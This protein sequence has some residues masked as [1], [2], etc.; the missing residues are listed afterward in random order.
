MT[1]F[2]TM[3]G[4]RHQEPATTPYACHGVF[5]DRFIFSLNLSRIQI[6]TGAPVTNCNH[7]HGLNVDMSARCRHVHVRLHV[8]G[9]WPISR[10]KLL[11]ID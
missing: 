8:H 3:A 9:N 2:S 5:T 4:A 1:R 11:K 10:E 7:K 6:P